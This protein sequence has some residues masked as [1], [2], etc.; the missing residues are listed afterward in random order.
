MYGQQQ[1]QQQQQQQ[2]YQQY[3]QQQQP[4]TSVG[5]ALA[6][7]A[8]PQQ[9]YYP[10]PVESSATSAATVEQE[11]QSDYV[12]SGETAQYSATEG[13]THAQST[14]ECEPDQQ[15]SPAEVDDQI[16]ASSESPV[17]AAGGGEFYSPS[18]NAMNAA[19]S[20][21]SYLDS[22]RTPGGHDGEEGSCGGDSSE[23]YQPRPSPVKDSLCLAGSSSSSSSSISDHQRKERSKERDE[24]KERAKQE[25]KATKRLLKELAVCKTILEEME[26]HEDSWPFLLPVNTKQF[27]TYRKV[28]KSPMDLSTIKKRLQDLVYKSREDFIADVRQIFDNC[29]VFNEDDSP[30]GIAGHGMR[31]FFEQRWADLTDKHS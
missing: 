31:K 4:S 12:A 13:Y 25:K 17:P 8:P 7:P 6:P 23:E 28:I 26:L 3:Y 30:V 24:A 14:S 11:A 27:P 5:S 20:S 10:T 22:D 18:S 15:E 2:Y 29:E 21:T 16:E 19:G 1:A 9:P